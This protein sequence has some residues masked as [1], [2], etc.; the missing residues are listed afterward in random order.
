MENKVK[1]TKRQIE[2][3]KTI[4]E[5][6]TDILHSFGD[7]YFGDEKTNMK[8]VDNLLRLCLIKCDDFSNFQETERYVITSTGIEAYK[9][10]YATSI[11]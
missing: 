1:L 7:T 5:Q 6:E 4:H 3:L 11:F 2:V 10:G 8:L 9:N